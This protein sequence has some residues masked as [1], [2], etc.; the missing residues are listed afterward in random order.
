MRPCDP[1]AAIQTS[2]K[3][4]KGLQL[5]QVDISTEEGKKLV[6]DFD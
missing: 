5:R 1:T 3:L 6:S 2:L 4:F